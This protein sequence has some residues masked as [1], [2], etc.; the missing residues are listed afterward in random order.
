MLFGK[1]VNKF[2]I[3]YGLWYLLGIIA[4]IAVDYFQLQIPDIIGNIIDNIQYKLLTRDML[5]DNVMQLVVVAL[6]MF[7]GRFFWRISIFGNGIKI[8]SDLRNE[9][10]YAMQRQSQSFFQENKTGALMTLY[11]NDLNMIRRVFGMGTI[12]LV[13]S[14]CLGSL[15]LYKMIKLNWRLSFVCFFA[16]IVITT[17]G[18]VLGKR[19]TKRVEEHYDAFSRLSDFVQEDIS[20]I[21]VIKAFVKEKLQISRFQKYNQENMDKNMRVVKLNV[22]VDVAIYTILSIIFA[23]IIIYGGLYINSLKNAG[24]LTFSIGDLTKFIAYFGTL[25]WPI[26]ALG[27]LIQLRSQGKASLNRV[28]RIIDLEEEVNDSQANHDILSLSGDIEFNDLTFAYPGSEIT[29]LKDVSFKIN[30]GEFVGIIGHTGSGKSTIVELLLRLYNINNDAIKIDGHDLMQIPLKVVRSNIAYVPQDTF[31][32]SKSI[33]D[34]VGFSEDEKIDDEKIVE[35]TKISNV[36]NDILEFSDGFDTVL[37]ERGVTV[38][39]GQKQR[40]AIAR[41]LYK[42]APILI[43]DDSLS[44]VDSETEKRIITKLREIRK[45]KTTII[46][47]HRISTLQNLDKIMVVEEGTVSHVGTHSELLQTSEAYANEV[48]FQELEKEAGMQDGKRRK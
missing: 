28:S 9:L 45:D 17:L 30:K 1:H 20:G 27:R 31:L 44:A 2:Y 24:E 37:G 33:I 19:I 32:F 39:G 4:L 11:T 13:D 16:L 22:G 6:I 40:I 15:T 41:A 8:E 38:S 42:N 48:R 34:N 25:I 23:S 26:E 5:K 18:T 14:L 3:R 7:L 35:T 36:Y 43:L 29:A 21:S 46:I 47:A 12:M 10:F